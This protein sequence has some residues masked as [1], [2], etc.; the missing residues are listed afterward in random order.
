MAKVLT[1][2]NLFVVGTTAG[3][4]SKAFFTY[5][6]QDGNAKKT[7]CVHNVENPDFSKKTDKFW[8]DELKLMKSAEKMA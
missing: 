2:V 5:D 7:G 4:P 8:N 3:G 6:V 1:N